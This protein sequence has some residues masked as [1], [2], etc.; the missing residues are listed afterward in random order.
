MEDSTLVE[1]FVSL[2]NADR[3]VAKHYLEACN[4]EL[5]SALNEYLENAHEPQDN[6]TVPIR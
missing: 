4:W 1:N 3:D 2:T 6:H 5:E